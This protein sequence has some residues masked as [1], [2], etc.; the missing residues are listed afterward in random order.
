MSVFFSI[1]VNAPLQ[2]GR[3]ETTEVGAV[4]AGPQRQ[5]AR[6]R[7]TRCRGTNRATASDGVEVVDSF[8]FAKFCV[9]Q[10]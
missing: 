8:N 7:A 6:H 10:M 9:I 3:R 2:G 5:R 4:A 1:P